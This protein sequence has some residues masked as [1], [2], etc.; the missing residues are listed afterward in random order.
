[1]KFE[2]IDKKYENKSAIE[3][4]NSPLSAFKGINEN[5]AKE[6]ESILQ[7]KSIRE[8][9]KIKFIRNAI[10]ILKGVK[11][12]KAWVNKNWEK[13]SAEEVA[14]ASLIALEGISKNSANVLQKI[15]KIKTVRDLAECKFVKWADEISLE[16][17]FEKALA[18]CDSIQKLRNMVNYIP[19]D[20][21][22]IKKSIELTND[23]LLPFP[24][25]S[26]LLN[27]CI[28]VEIPAWEDQREDGV[29]TVIDE[30]GEEKEID[31]YRIWENKTSVFAKYNKISS[32]KN[33]LFLI[34]YNEWEDG[35]LGCD[36]F[37]E[38]GGSEG[39][40]CLDYDEFGDDISS[41]DFNGYGD[42][43]STYY[44]SNGIFELIL[45]WEDEKCTINFD[46]NVL[47]YN[48]NELDMSLDHIIKFILKV[49]GYT[50]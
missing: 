16:A 33:L 43:E 28:T 2:Y 3:I 10:S 24:I 19:K 5:A 35:S 39:K 32:L 50:P 9:T 29:F 17:D 40:G 27:F 25:F 4:A 41:E 23:T 45:E 12:K 1:M 20:E 31:G 47:I 21:R 36:E 15:L 26:P 48:D 44:G 6:L 13:K 14:G 22:L 46:S 30:D 37:E 42:T 8:L 34:L 7:I 18:K 49:T 11:P 38:S